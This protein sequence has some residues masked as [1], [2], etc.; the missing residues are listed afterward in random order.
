MIEAEREQQ[1]EVIRFKAL[2]LIT[3][4][5]A[6]RLGVATESP[7][8]VSPALNSKEKCSICDISYEPLIYQTEYQINSHHFHQTRGGIY[9]IERPLVL[10]GYF[11]AVIQNFSTGWISMLEP[12]GQNG[13]IGEGFGGY[14]SSSEE[15]I[16]HS[17]R[18]FCINE[19]CMSMSKS[20][21]I[22]K[23]VAIEK[24]TGSLVPVCGLEEHPEY[25]SK[26]R[27][28]FKIEEGIVLFSPI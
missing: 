17:I 27:Y 28:N 11:N 19:Y 1:T 8:F 21:E 23:G 15:T 6:N 3:P 13:R 18:A 4:E 14:V 2:R 24:H 20:K 26:A 10:E 7:V 5:F 16:V 9:Y 25:E 22:K 12:V